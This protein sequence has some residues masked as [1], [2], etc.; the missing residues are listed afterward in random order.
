[1]L[2]LQGKIEF[3][4]IEIVLKF[5]IYLYFVRFT[6]IGFASLMLLLVRKTIPMKFF[7]SSKATLDCS[8]FLSLLAYWLVSWRSN[9]KRGEAN[10]SNET[11]IVNSASSGFFRKTDCHFYPDQ[12]L[13]MFVFVHAASAISHLSRTFLNS[14][15]LAVVV[16][17]CIGIL[18][19]R[20]HS[21]NFI[22]SCFPS[23][24]IK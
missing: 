16:P 8:F 22:D 23:H 12:N 11:H 20:S 15:S 10:F 5:F 21:L 13:K 4:R 18:T 3:L 7:S 24:F 14:I 19:I 17:Y 6:L 1:M 9:S 2:T